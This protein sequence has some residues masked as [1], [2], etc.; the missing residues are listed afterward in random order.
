M[1]GGFAAL[2]DLVM[3]ACSGL[4]FA[5]DE[6]FKSSAVIG[7][8]CFNI[9]PGESAMESFLES[10]IAV[11]IRKPGRCARCDRM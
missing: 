9:E 1:N 5:R 8:S 2:A 3:F 7:C 4:S 11:N 6:V 10:F